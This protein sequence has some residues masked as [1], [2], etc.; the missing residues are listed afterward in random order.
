MTFDLFLST[1][2]LYTVFM[3]SFKITKE[4]VH[5]TMWDNDEYVMFFF[6][7]ESTSVHSIAELLYYKITEHFFLALLDY[8]LLPAFHSNLLLLFLRPDR[9]SICFFLNQ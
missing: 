5:A 6:Y 1:Y 4:T 7:C 9:I 2:Y 3:L 8:L